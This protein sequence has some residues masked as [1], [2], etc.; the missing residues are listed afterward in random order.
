MENR[1][2]RSVFA[3]KLKLFYTLDINCPAWLL[4]PAYTT[5]QILVGSNRLYSSSIEK[6][7]ASSLSVFPSSF[8]G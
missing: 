5:P 6:N 3:V 1:A 2:F 8:E 4:A 7:P